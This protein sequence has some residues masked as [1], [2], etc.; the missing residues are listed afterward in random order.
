M[1]Q[2]SRSASAILPSLLVALG[3]GAS[4]LAQPATDATVTIYLKKDAS[5]RCASST[6]GIAEVLQN[7]TIAWEVVHVKSEAGGCPTGTRVQVQFPKDLLKDFRVPTTQPSPRSVEH[8]VFVADSA[9]IGARLKD[10]DKE[11]LG[12]YASGAA[13]AP[14]G[15]ITP[16]PLF[17]SRATAK[18]V[19]GPGLYKYNVRIEGGAIEDPPIRVLPPP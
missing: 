17:P 9:R 12:R 15:A 5:G 7:G 16:G 10:A 18:V 14:G 19:G 6:P 11:M 1:R 3:V 4:L 8:T 13:A 2:R